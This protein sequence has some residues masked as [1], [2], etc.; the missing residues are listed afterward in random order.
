MIPDPEDVD[1]VVDAWRGALWPRDPAEDDLADV[2]A[3]YSE[4]HRAYHNIRHICSVLDMVSEC[5]H[6]SAELVFAAILHDVIYDPRA[7]D[8]EEQSAK[9][10]R[11]LLTHQNW[12][13]EEIDRVAELILAT[14][15]HE[16][17]ED[18]TQA[19][20]LLDADLA[21]L[22]G[23]E[24]SYDEYAAAI[25]EEYSFVPDSD[26]R[27]GR[28]KVLQSFLDRPRIFRM[29]DNIEVYEDAARK[30]IAAEIRRLSGQAN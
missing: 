23:Y 28:I 18:D 10:A 16:A 2:L 29:P 9:Y 26:Y 30:N 12:P 7:Q 24:G 21:I 22:A 15:H 17:P 19:S 6:Q 4:P 25:R 5:D 8:N 11:D 1:F 27:V 14:K 13:L 20:I 3:R